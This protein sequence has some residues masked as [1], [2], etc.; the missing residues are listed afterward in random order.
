MKTQLSWVTFPCDP[1]CRLLSMA[2]NKL[3][4]IHSQLYICFN[5]FFYLS[6][7]VKHNRV[8]F[9][10]LYMCLFTN[11]KT[12]IKNR[13]QYLCVRYSATNEWIWTMAAHQIF[14]GKP[15]LIRMKI[16]GNFGNFHFNYEIF[17]LFISIINKY[18]VAITF[19]IYDQI[20][21]VMWK[22]THI[23]Y[24]WNVILSIIQSVYWH[25][26][27]LKIRQQNTFYAQHFLYLF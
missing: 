20:I 2:W 14:N 3:I 15:A 17:I 26:M 24:N 4:N 18:H 6:I 9:L 1:T 23:I 25:I 8:I 22:V 5:F 27:K 21:T 10:F 13:N 19:H 7:G 16:I 11:Y 12:T